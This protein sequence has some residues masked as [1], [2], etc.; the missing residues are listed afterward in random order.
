M[1]VAKGWYAIGG[2]DPNSYVNSVLIASNS[3]LSF[4]FYCDYKYEDSDCNSDLTVT[5]TEVNLN[6]LPI[7][8][9]L[10]EVC[11]FGF[12][13]TG[14]S[15]SCIS[16]LE[17]HNYTCDINSL[18]FTSPTGY[19]TGLVNDTILFDRNCPPH[20]C[21]HASNPSTWIAPSLIY[22]V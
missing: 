22:L 1:Y 9:I 6:P 12:N 7:I 18:L 11:P 21:N 5:N 8:S 14:Y 15:C 19:W 13:L 17:A 4:T 3:T 16:V 2:I 10:N 20:Y